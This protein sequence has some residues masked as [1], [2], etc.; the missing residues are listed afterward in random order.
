[1]RRK[2]KKKV[3]NIVKEQKE[4]KKRKHEE[5]CKRKLQHLRETR[6]NVRKINHYIK[7]EYKKNQ[8]L[9]H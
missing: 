3:S 2:N 8:L 7:S 4:E 5:K 6:S 1:M 9:I